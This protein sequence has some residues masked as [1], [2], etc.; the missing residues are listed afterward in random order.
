[1]N[2]ANSMLGTNTYNALKDSCV[3][4]EKNVIKA[5]YIK[6]GLTILPPKGLENYIK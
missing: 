3:S 4:C 6:S 2:K 5:G 1:M